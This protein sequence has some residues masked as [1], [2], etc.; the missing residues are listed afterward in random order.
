MWDET[1]KANNKTMRP[2][3]KAALAAALLSLT[4]VVA[5]AQDAKL[6][7]SP[8]LVVSGPTDRMALETD[9]TPDLSKVTV[10]DITIAPDH[11]VR[12]I[13]VMDTAP[14]SVGI[15]LDLA[16]NAQLGKRTVTVTVGGKA[17][18]GELD[19]IQGAAVVVEVPGKPSKTKGVT[20]LDVVSRAGVDLGA[21]KPADIKVEPRDATVVEITNQSAD[22]FTLGLKIPA[23]RKN[24]SGTLRIGGEVK[25]A[26]DFSLA[27][28]HAPKAC[29]KLQHCCDGEGEACKACKPIDQVCRK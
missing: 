28:P 18:G 4:A 23:A 26:A 14:K 22:G 17:A 7:L 21:I 27:G 19:V 2:S 11:D 5:A 20:T 6:T 8:A 15:A 10:R 25:L 16:G 3:I 29:G 24:L 13:K 1:N 9:G 12:G